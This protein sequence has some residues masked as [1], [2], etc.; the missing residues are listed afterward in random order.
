VPLPIISG[1]VRATVR[2]LMPSGKP[3]TNSWYF[4][5]GSG[6]PWSSAR[7]A[8]FDA[9]FKKLYSGPAYPSGQAILTQCTSLVTAVDVVYTPLDGSSS[10][11]VTNWNVAGTTAGDSLPSEVCLVWTFRTGL[12]GPANRG[13]VF[14]PANYEG[15]NVSN[16]TVNASV[17][18]FLTAQYTGFV[19]D[20]GTNTFTHMVVSVL[21]GTSH[22]V[23]SVSMDGKWDVQRR[24][25]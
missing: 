22:T 25:K 11:T 8:T 4:H 14:L 18:T 3:W 12:R 24:R 20:L 6:S 1:G 17:I 2:G 15:N 5:D 19:G 13:R 16:G 9:F 21:H 23:T 7:I 10:S